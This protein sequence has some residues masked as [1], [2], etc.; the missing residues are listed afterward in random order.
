MSTEAVRWALDQKIGRMTRKLV[1]V[2]IAHHADKNGRNAFPGQ[3]TI[4]D[5]LEQ[6]ERTARK[7][8]AELESGGY[9]RRD[10]RIDPGGHRKSDVYTLSLPENVL[11][12]GLPEKNGESYRKKQGGPTGNIGSG[13]HSK[14]KPRKKDTSLRSVSRAREPA[15]VAVVVENSKVP[16]VVGTKFPPTWEELGERSLAYALTHG[17]DRD[18]AAR[19]FQHFRAHQIMVGHVRENWLAA[20][21]VWVCKQVEINNDKRA[22]YGDGSKGSR[23]VVEAF[24]K[25][26]HR[27]QHSAVAAAHKLLRR[28]EAEEAC[29]GS[30]GEHYNGPILDLKPEPPAEP[31]V[32]KPSQARRD[33]Q[34]ESVRRMGAGLHS[35]GRR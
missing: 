32:C 4:A 5:M 16:A 27:E 18:E 21:Q 34:A 12:V 22:R 3:S 28:V 33:E 10:R 20:W 23:T 15:P 11:P 6:T 2:I 7:Y 24:D 30:N 9:L 19:A 31:E 25:I 26:L 8:I 14:R 17:L 35:K 29:G 13:N 1:L